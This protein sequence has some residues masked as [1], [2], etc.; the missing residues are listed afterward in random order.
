M[1]ECADDE[2]VVDAQLQLAVAGPHDHDIDLVISVPLG[3]SKE[4]VDATAQCENSGILAVFI[5]YQKSE[6][7]LICI[8]VWDKISE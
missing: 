2:G 1:W 7:L 3:G 4:K 8:H 5:S 6:T